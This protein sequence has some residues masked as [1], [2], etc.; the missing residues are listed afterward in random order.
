MNARVPTLPT[1]TTLRAMSTN[2]NRSRRWR[3]S[4]C[5]R[6]PV[7]AELLVDHVLELVDGEADARRRRSRNGITIGGWLTIR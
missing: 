1:P 4:S 3:R 6:R 2:S 7:G 5:K